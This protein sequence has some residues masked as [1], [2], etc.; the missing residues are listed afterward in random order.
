M[1]LS[2]FQKKKKG[3]KEAMR[4]VSA[5]NLN[6]QGNSPGGG[7]PNARLD[8]IPNS[9]THDLMLNPKRPLHG[10][11]LKMPRPPQPPRTKKFINT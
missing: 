7:S 6:A 8:P 5:P 1:I 9:P 3:E 11:G 2:H 4:Y 10:D